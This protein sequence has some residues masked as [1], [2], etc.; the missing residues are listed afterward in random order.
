MGA[1]FSTNQNN[2]PNVGSSQENDTNSASSL[3]ATLLPGESPHLKKMSSRLLVVYE[4]IR[5]S[6][7]FR[8]RVGSSLSGAEKQVPAILQTANIRGQ[9]PR[10]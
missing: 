4:L 2:D 1:C 3:Y 9:S 6:V 8:M 7:H 5:R 10:K